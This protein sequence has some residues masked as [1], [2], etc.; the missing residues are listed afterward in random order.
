MAQLLKLGGVKIKKP[1]T[2]DLESYNITK[3]GRTT[4][5]IMHLDFIANKRK[6]LFTYDVLAGDDLTAILN[7]IDSGTMFFTIEY[8]DNNVNRSATVYVGVIKKTQFRTDGV[9]YWK[10]A[11]FNL[12]EK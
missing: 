2:F 1:T 12:I 5:G 7:I 6:F 3:A 11:T 8:K 10:K 9:W 4:D